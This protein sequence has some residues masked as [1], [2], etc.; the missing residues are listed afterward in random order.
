MEQLSQYLVLVLVLVP[1]G[2]DGGY[3]ATSGS[4]RIKKFEP[5]TSLILFYRLVVVM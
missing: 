5:G 4:G 2:Y 1:G 3:P